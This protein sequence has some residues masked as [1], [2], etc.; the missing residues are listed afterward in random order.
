ML[1]QTKL[2]GIFIFSIITLVSCE[3]ESISDWKGLDYPNY[4]PPPNQ[5]VI[6]NR[7]FTKQ[8]FYLGKKLFYDPILSKDSTISCGSCHKQSGAF[9]DIGQNQSL[10]IRGQ[11]GSRNTPA[12]QN[13]V[14]QPTYFHDGGVFN[15]DLISLAPIENP[16]EMEESIH[17]IIEKMKR[18]KEYP[19]L[20]KSYFGTDE[21][22]SARILTAITQFQAMLISSNSKYDQYLQGKATLSNDEM[23]GKTLFQKKCSSCHSSEL[24]SDFQF[25]NNGIVTKGNDSGRYRITL[26][27]SDKYKFKTPSLR[28]IVKSYPYMHDGSILTLEGVLEH[29]NSGVKSNTALDSTLKNGIPMTAD[30]QRKIILFLHTL[31]DEEFLANKLFSNN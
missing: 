8:G 14:F 9:S 29:Y 10:G 4:F 1:S 5:A 7:K 3:K 24:F 17:Q 2:V 13:L 25:R 28:N 12:L 26:N 22:T 19:T 27:E 18:S 20:F 30:E 21:I 15:I 11:L 23:E 16:L 6:Q 31:T